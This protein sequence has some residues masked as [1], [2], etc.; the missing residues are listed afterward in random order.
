MLAATL[1]VPCT[2]CR[3]LSWLVTDQW[4]TAPFSKVYGW[5]EPLSS[6]WVAEDSTFWRPCSPVEPEVKGC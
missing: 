2:G 5:R 3:F 6:V 4:V 1:P